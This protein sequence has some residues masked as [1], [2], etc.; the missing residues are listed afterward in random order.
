MLERSLEGKYANLRSARIHFG[1]IISMK[2]M[3]ILTVNIKLEKT[4]KRSLKFILS[5]YLNIKDETLTENYI[6]CEYFEKK[7]SWQNSFS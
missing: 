6:L 4:L 7:I 3:Q 2:I 5:I 1:A